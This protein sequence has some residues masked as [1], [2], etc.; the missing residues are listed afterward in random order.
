MMAPVIFEKYNEVTFFEPTEWFYD[1][2]TRNSYDKY[3]LQCAAK[4]RNEQPSAPGGYHTTGGSFS[5]PIG[6][7]NSIRQAGRPS[8]QAA[9][10]AASVGVAAQ[11][12]A[13]Y[14]N[15]LTMNGHK[16]LMRAQ[17]KEL[18]K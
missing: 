8:L 16:P 6:Q 3:R 18:M 13:K 1:I 4:S 7:A 9:D 11:K 12:M 10:T 5:H 14:Q 2:L 17:F 15:Y